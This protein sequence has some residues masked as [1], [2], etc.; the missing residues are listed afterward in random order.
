ML[1]S[2]REG[3]RA[4]RR[5]RDRVVA[6]IGHADHQR[7]PAIARCHDR[8]L[9]EDEAGARPREAGEDQSG[10]HREETHA[11]K[12]FDG[13][14]EMAV[15]GLRMHVA[16][17]D[18]RQ[19]LDREVEEL[20]R[21][22]AGD[23]GDRSIAE[24]IEQREDGIEHDENRARRCRRTPASKRSSSDDRGRSRNPGSGRGSRSRGADTDQMGIC[25]RRSWP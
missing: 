11:G 8:M 4:A 19:R 2:R 5:P 1:R 15:I 7:R 6:R 3:A 21:P 17:A 18:R 24:R 22:V 9:G 12:D 13:G 10:H 25:A 23:I 16:V 20:Q 14:D